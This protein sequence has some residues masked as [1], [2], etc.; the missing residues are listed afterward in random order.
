MVFLAFM[1]TLFQL[2]TGYDM[3]V[4]VLDKEKGFFMSY[5]R[6]IAA[7]DGSETSK[8]VINESASLAAALQAKLG[9]IHVM[10]PI[11]IYNL[12]VGFDL[13][14]YV[15][16]IRKEGQTLLAAM[17]E[18]ATQQGITAETH[19]IEMPN[20]SETTSAK[21]IVTATTWRA[22][23]LAIGTHGR[24]GFRRFLLGSVAEETLRTTPIPILL[25]RAREKT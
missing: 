20:P 9:I 12:P 16:F 18:I 8:L 7:V 21:I 24:R 4:A 11:P 1:T 19:L 14:E 3:M 5:K 2:D 17:H 23:L 22:D 25:I 15:N 13:L 6:I 10:D